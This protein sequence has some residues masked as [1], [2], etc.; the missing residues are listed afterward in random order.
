M[1]AAIYARI[2]TDKQSAEAQAGVAHRMV[3]WGAGPSWSRGPDT[4]ETQLA[5]RDWR[6]MRPLGGIL[7]ALH[8]LA[9]APGQATKSFTGT[10]EADAAGRRAG[11]GAALPGR[12]S[13]TMTKLTKRLDG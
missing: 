7:A 5:F 13:T 4:S 1:R 11:R 10:D 2:S 12:S 9:N 3:R 6:E 8:E